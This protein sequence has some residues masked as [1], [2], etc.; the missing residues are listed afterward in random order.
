MPW[1]PEDR[2]RRIFE[3]LWL[4][5]CQIAAPEHTAAFILAGA[6]VLTRMT[7]G[8]R[9]HKWIGLRHQNS[10]PGT[11]FDLGVLPY[12]KITPIH[13]IMTPERP[14][15][16]EPAHLPSLSPRA[17]RICLARVRRMPDFQRLRTLHLGDDHGP[18]QRQVDWFEVS[19]D[20][21]RVWQAYTQYPAFHLWPG[22]RVRYLFSYSK[23]DQCF[24][25]TE[26]YPP[27]AIHVG[28][29]FFCLLD[30]GIPVGLVGMELMQLD[31]AQKLLELAYIEGGLYRGFQ[32]VQFHADGPRRTRIEH[33][34]YQRGEAAWVRY[35]IPYQ[36]L[37]RLTTG[38]FHDHLRRLIER[39]EAKASGND[40]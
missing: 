33:I 21:E 32:T 29:Q 9:P 13:L 38:E 15:V 27:P 24:A 14:A 22:P 26:A 40:F 2:L 37:H 20:V 34:S 28:Q 10:R 7:K 18:Y 39:E 5:T 35:L 1:T 17:K 36:S 12:G 6:E 19:A 25:Y 3:K 16:F 8:L 30:F 11:L 23:R 4:R 31:P